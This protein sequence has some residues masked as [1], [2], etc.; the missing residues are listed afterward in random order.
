M[1]KMHTCVNK[2]LIVGLGSIGKRHIEIIRDLFP[3][4]TIGLLR[5]SK[6]NKDE[7]KS[8]RDNF[9]KTMNSEGFR[10]IK[11]NIDNLMIQLVLNRIRLGENNNFTPQEQIIIDAIKRSDNDLNDASIV[12][13]SES[14]NFS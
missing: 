9:K 3:E 14:F 10:Y 11:N 12:D 4:I 1:R 5:H 6:C 7:I 8:H 13:I 2:I